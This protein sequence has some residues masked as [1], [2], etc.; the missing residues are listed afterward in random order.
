MKVV[1]CNRGTNEVGVLLRRW[2]RK[3]VVYY[4]VMTERGILVENLTTSLDQPCY[5]LET[6]SLKLNEK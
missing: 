1:L 2:R 5:V 4:N 6:L 3:G